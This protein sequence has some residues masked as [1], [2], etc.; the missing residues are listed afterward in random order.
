MPINDE[1]TQ[2]AIELGRALANSIEMQELEALRDD[3][4]AEDLF[5]Q[6]TELVKA[7]F[8]RTAQRISTTMG[9][10]YTDFVK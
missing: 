8:S 7:L 4:D 3:P 1:L 10:R 6:R 5:L 2:S 9:I